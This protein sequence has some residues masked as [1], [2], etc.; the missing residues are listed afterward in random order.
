MND[1]Y[2]TTKH[3][4][5]HIDGWGFD[6]NEYDDGIISIKYVDDSDGAEQV[7]EGIWPDSARMIARFLIDLADRIERERTMT[8]DGTAKVPETPVRTREY[9][10]GFIAG[11][12]FAAC[13]HK[14]LESAIRECVPLGKDGA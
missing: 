6:V 10:E 11:M 2:E 9:L 4:V 13:T 14:C 5:R 7:V 1:F 12:E 3:S 8:C